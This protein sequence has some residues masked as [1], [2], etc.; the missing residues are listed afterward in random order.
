[1]AVFCVQVRF[2][3]CNVPCNECDEACSGLKADVCV[4][5]YVFLVEWRKCEAFGGQCGVWEV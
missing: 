3:T 5:C 4:C 2:V 1:V